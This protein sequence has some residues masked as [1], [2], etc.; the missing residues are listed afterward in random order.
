MGHDRRRSISSSSSS[1]SS[2]DEGHRKP[3]KKD[4]KNK[5]HHNNTAHQ[6]GILPAGVP[7]ADYRGVVDSQPPT[8][9][10]F[11]SS[12]TMSGPGFP[13][14]PA[15]PYGSEN[16]QFSMPGAE[17]HQQTFQPPPG[18]P[19]SFPSHSPGFPSPGHEGEQH[20]RGFN[21]PGFPNSPQ[22]TSPPPSSAHTSAPPSGIRV[23]LTTTAPFPGPQQV[24]QPVAMDLD[25][26]SPVFV[27]SAI[28]EKSVHP[29]KIVP[30]L[31]PPC[32]V[33]YGG[34][35][36]E[37]NGRY[38]LLPFDPATMEWVPTSHGRLPSGRR[39]VEGGY[40]DHGGKLYHA[41]AHI[42]G[43]NVPGK[44]G[45][46]L[47][48]GNYCPMFSKSLKWYLLGRMQ[49]CICRRGARHTGELP[50]LVRFPLLSSGPASKANIRSD[51]CWR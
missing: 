22:H 46:H 27:G 30:D 34:G 42:S 15:Y 4:K 36:F 43:V 3:R 40:E 29:C 5:H 17:H 32:R 48:S 13:S 10:A 45:E 18:P 28:L 33:P 37:H 49:C 12:T 38:D 23:P 35:E 7:Y 41:L 50:N 11:P 9:S 1:S 2:S 21:P 16:T 20:D 14:G 31:N 26:R 39:L 25:G 47:V 44:T 51:R 24:G 19:P 6:A 8:Y